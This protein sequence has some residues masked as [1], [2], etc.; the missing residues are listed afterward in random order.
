[1]CTGTANTN[2]STINLK[3]CMY[4]Y[5]APFKYH[6]WLVKRGVYINPRLM[7]TDAHS[8]EDKSLFET[9]QELLSSKAEL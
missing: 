6:H 5:M 3:K 7:E 4:H 8:W 9:L 2:F 1:M